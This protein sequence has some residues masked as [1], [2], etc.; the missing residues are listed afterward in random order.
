MGTFNQHEIHYTDERGISLEVIV[1]PGAKVVEI[2]ASANIPVYLE[3]TDW[4]QLCLRVNH[5]LA[6]PTENVEDGC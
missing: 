5:Y 4:E 6:Q 2:S 3:L 1:T